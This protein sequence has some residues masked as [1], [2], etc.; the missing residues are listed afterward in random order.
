MKTFT[1]LLMLLSW[2]KKFSLVLLPALTWLS[3]TKATS[4]SIPPLSS[5]ADPSP[6]TAATATIAASPKPLNSYTD[7]AY[8]Y[9]VPFGTHSHWLQP[10]RAYLETVPAKTFLDGVGINMGLEPN[11]ADPNLL[12]QMLSKHGIRNGRLEIVWGTADY[13]TEKISDTWLRQQ[14]QAAKKWG[15]RPVIL[16]TAHQGYPTPALYFQRTVTKAAQAG[17][18]TVELD[19]T[20]NLIVGRSGINN[21]TD[22]WK[23]EALVTAISGN[24]VTL[25]KRLP[26]AIDA[27]SPIQMATLKYL[28]FSAPGTANY[29]QTIQGWQKFVGEAARFA[30]DALG[31]TNSADKGFDLEIWNEATIFGSEFLSIDNYYERPPVKYDKNSIWTNLVAATADYVKVHPAQFKGVKISNGF[32]NTSEKIGASTLPKSINAIS[33]HPYSSRLTYPAQTWGDTRIDALGKQ[34][35]FIPSYSV[36]FPE[37]FGTA[38][39]GNNLIR[40]FGPFT[41][42][43]G[44][45]KHGRYARVIDRQ[46]VPTEVW[47]TEIGI[48][49]TKDGFNQ[50]SATNPAIVGVASRNENRQ[51]GLNL[52][53]KTT[54]RYYTFYLNKGVSK[55]QLFSASTGDAW[56]G[57]VQDNFLA[58]AKTN[59]VYPK[60]DSSY[61][62]PALKITGRIV[63]QMKRNLDPSLTKT[64][65]LRLD[66]VGDTHNQ[67]Q[68]GGDGTA[69]HPPLYNRDVFAFLPYQVNSKRFVI[70]YYVMTRDVTKNLPPAKFAIQISKLKAQGAT[71]SVYDPMHDRTVPISIDRRGRDFLKLTL[72][73]TDYPYLLIIQE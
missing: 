45:V 16:L 51:T 42:K 13:R 15:I 26:K 6:P 11:R 52:K 7:P 18:R 41:E 14:L 35:N 54:A 38:L 37:F 72:S 40:D 65:Q 31:T 32:A 68:F 21:L 17:S 60:E 19:D 8:F 9:D 73:A 20:S 24:T 44:G 33:K 30:S 3:M 48:A 25:S 56:L 59:N 62:S 10:W 36:L 4:F 2:I 70:P 55:V 57:I 28:P 61:V 1:N 66:S 5:I 47:I 50:P 29:R 63:A 53:A 71:V 34:T 39:S 58:Y 69:A 12:A 67:M 22:N 49:P 43:I 46:V 23:A 27:G 64:R